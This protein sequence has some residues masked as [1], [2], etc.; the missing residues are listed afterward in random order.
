MNREM[1]TTS[2]L[3]VCLQIR[4]EVIFY[5]PTLGWTVEEASLLC[6]VS[7]Y[8]LTVQPRVGRWMYV[9]HSLQRLNE[10]STL[11][12]FFSL[13]NRVAFALPIPSNLFPSLK[14]LPYIIFCSKSSK[15]S[16]N[17]SLM[18]EPSLFEKP[19]GF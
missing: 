8:S 5:R 18:S 10:S 17:Q 7:I 14:T 9:I 16:K 13:T 19:A 2:A 11:G 15:A 6:K 4:K 3:P 1:W 12:I